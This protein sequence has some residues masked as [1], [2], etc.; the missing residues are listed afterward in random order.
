M[1]LIKGEMRRLKP[2]QLAAKAD[3]VVSKMTGNPNFATPNPDLASITDAST[4][5]QK[6]MK[7]AESKSP[8]DIVVRNTADAVLRDLM[9]ALVRYVNSVSM[10]NADMAVSSGFE[11]SKKPEPAEKL[12]APQHLQAD[13][14][15]YAGGV[16]LRW[17]RVHHARMYQVYIN[18]T[19]PVTGEWKLLG[20]TSKARYE[21]LHLES[22]KVYNFKVTAS[23]RVGEG[24]ASEYVGKRAA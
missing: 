21:A 24:P 20:Y 2:G 4:A 3:Y 10:G 17:E 11:L 6:A 16:D 7:Q 13:F 12:D 15:Q 23:G 1:N 8:A 19:D 9:S 14:S 18:E 22:G 5:L